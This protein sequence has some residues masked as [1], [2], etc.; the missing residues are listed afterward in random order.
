MSSGPLN[1]RHTSSMTKK[2][3]KKLRYFGFPP[4]LGHRKLIDLANYVPSSSP[5]GVLASRNDLQHMLLKSNELL[6]AWPS[7]GFLPS[8]PCLFWWIISANSCLLV[9]NSIIRWKR[10]KTKRLCKVNTWPRGTPMKRIHYANYDN[11]TSI[12]W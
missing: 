6:P 1:F 5:R 3:R 10:G 11:P 9:F 7:L 2:I 4:N 12:I 8:N